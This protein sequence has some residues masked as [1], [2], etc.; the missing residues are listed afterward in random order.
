MCPLKLGA[1]MLALALTSASER[2]EVL[3]R[4]YASREEVVRDGAIDRGWIPAWIPESAREI[5]E[6]H[7]IDTNTSQLAFTF[8]AF[9]TARVSPSCTPALPAKIAL[10]RTSMADWWPKELRG[11]SS[12]LDRFSFFEC[13]EEREP[14]GY[15]AVDANVSK[16]YFWREWAS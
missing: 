12:Q 14:H 10:P 2:W 8:A 13:R 15:L 4:A 5:R 7:N 6:I 11:G 16:A 9:D 3:E 1:S